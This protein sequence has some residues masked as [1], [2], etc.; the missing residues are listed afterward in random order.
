MKHKMYIYIIAVFIIAFLT[1][2]ILV[3]RGDVSSIGTSSSKNMVSDSTKENNVP[4]EP[5]E[6]KEPKPSSI[7]VDIFNKLSKDE[8]AKIEDFIQ[9]SI[10]SECFF[11][12]VDNL[13]SD[14]LCKIIYI[15]YNNDKTFKNKVKP[16]KV[17]KISGDLF[18]KQKIFGVAYDYLGVKEI[19]TDPPTGLGLK[20][21][22][23]Y[24]EFSHAAGDP[25]NKPKVYKIEQNN[26]FLNVYADVI[27]IDENINEFQYKVKV[28]ISKDGSSIFGY[29]IISVTKTEN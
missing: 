21:T 5:K 7:P 11:D 24:F 25:Q 3:K 10:Q 20:Y 15:L 22:N 29:K 17:G 14:D 28:I 8:I 12:K 2:V 1:G 9:S 26:S 4:K 16:D 18:S 19:S 27:L 13:S 23:G 6:P